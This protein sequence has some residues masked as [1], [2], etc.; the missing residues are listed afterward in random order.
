MKLIPL[1]QGKFAMVDDEDFEELSR[2][3]WYAHRGGRSWYA[4]RNAWV[5]GAGK[6]RCV[7]MHSRITGFDLTDHIDGDGLNNQRANLRDATKAQNG[8]NRRR[9]RNGSSA[10]KGVTRDP[11]DAGWYAGIRRRYIGRYRSEEEAALAYDAAA[12]ELYGAY[13]ALNFPRPGERSAL[14]EAVAA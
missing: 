11:R 1:T 6:Q 10:F 14:T 13:A 3:K 7:L 12:R 4:R 9:N 2:F 8:Q 5:A